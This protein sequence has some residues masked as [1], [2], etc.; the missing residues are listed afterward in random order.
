[1][2][3]DLAET[4]RSGKVGL[5]EFTNQVCDHIESNEPNIQAL[6][7]ESARRERLLA[8]AEQLL[9]RYPDPSSRP[10]LFGVPVGIKDVFH[11]DGFETRAG[12]D[13]PSD[14]FAGPEA[15]VVTRLKNAGALILGKTVATEFAFSDP[16]PTRNPHNPEHTPGGSSSGSAAAVAAGYCPLALG[17][18]TIGSIARPASYCGVVGFKPT[19]DRIPSTGCVPFSD[20]VDHVGFFVPDIR[21]VRYVAPLVCDDWNRAAREYALE[22]TSVIG[23]PV[24]DYLEQAE[25]EM[26]AMLNREIERLK[27]AGHDI[28]YVDLF[29]DWEERV[30]LH[31]DLIAAEMAEYHRPWFEQYRSVYRDGSRG[32]IERGLGVSVDTAERARAEQRMVRDHVMQCM[33]E[34]GIDRWITPSATSAAP[35]GLD[36]TGNPLMNL[37]WTYSGLPTLTV[38]LGRSRKG[39]PLGV[40]WVGRYAEDEHLLV[41]VLQEAVR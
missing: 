21:S 38:P 31:Y 40:Q 35:R 39:M 19:Y 33:D 32:L 12:S 11:V 24:G 4:L 16:G 18:Q 2:R 7:P 8:D 14:L 25:L 26:R 9:V 5:V 17:T 34:Q 41:N 37:P 1:M 28:R 13:L 20:S 36:S 30:K 3:R 27:E 10:P 15:T 22:E 23:V 6:L 29:P